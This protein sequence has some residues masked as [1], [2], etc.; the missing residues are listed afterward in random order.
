MGENGNMV[1]LKEH[2]E[3]LV[4]SMDRLFLEKWEH[5]NTLIKLKT[6]GIIRATDIAKIEV[7]DKLAKMN[8]MR[9][10]LDKQN[11]TFPTRVEL[12]LTVKT[13]E[14]ADV[15]LRNDIQSLRDSRNTF[16]G[17]DT[18]KSAIVGWNLQ[19]GTLIVAVIGLAV[20]LIAIFK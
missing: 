1:S 2:F 14:E 12:E 18:Q 6:E 15:L 5:L 4:K 19:V 11:A 8:E 13:L 9:S 3:V 7:D 17:K 16:E 20:A 10:Q